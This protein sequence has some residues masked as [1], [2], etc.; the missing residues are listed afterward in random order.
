[1][2]RL[3]AAESSNAMEGMNGLGD[4]TSVNPVIRVGCWRVVFFP[5]F[6]T[7]Q[8]ATRDTMAVG[9]K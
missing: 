1:M 7:G 2:L 5:F 6:S 9:Q 8:N 3:V 4:G